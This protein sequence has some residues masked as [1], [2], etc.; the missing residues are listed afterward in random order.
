MNFKLTV[1]IL[2][3]PEVWKKV[4][5]GFIHSNLILVRG[6]YKLRVMTESCGIW[7]IPTVAWT[8]TAL[9]FL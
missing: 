6:P 3:S 9:Q 5:F 8:N 1:K 2:N 7:M 4:H